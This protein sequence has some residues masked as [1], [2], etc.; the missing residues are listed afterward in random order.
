MSTR[1]VEKP[2]RYPGIREA[3]I[4]VRSAGT[5]KYF[6]VLV[7]EIRKGVPSKTFV[8][9][10]KRIGLGQEELA[11][12][13]GLK[14]RTIASRLASREKKLNPNESERVLRIK[15]IFDQAVHVFGSE[16]EAREW[17]MNPAYGLEGQRPVD[18]MDTEP[19]SSQVREYL[20][21]IEQGNYW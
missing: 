11:R 2:P 7:E 8:E 1:E 17:L 12:K 18:L 4:V 6:R 13:L 9:T 5:G 16:E 3:K 20:G 19:G 21:A 10:A 14:P 15:Q